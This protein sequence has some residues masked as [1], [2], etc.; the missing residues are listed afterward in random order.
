MVARANQVFDAIA[1]R[2]F[3]IFDGSGHQFGNELDD[4]L[5]AEQELLHPVHVEITESDGVLTVRAEVPGFRERDIKVSVEP[6]RLTITGKRESRPEKK[7]KGKTVYPEQCSD[8]IFRV[9]ALPATVET[10]SNAVKATYAQGV[11]TVTL[12]RAKPADGGQITLES[13]STHA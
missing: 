3:E 5:K 2:A 10:S 6:E 8:E 1:R 13:T 4:W 9:V 12:P 11:V 7:H